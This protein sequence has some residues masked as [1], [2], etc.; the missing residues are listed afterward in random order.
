MNLEH[1]LMGHHQGTHRQIFRLLRQERVTVNDA[2]VVAGHQP[3]ETT[4]R[5][6]VDGVE[7]TGRQPQYL[8]FNRPLGFQDDLTPTT[9]RS[10]GSLLNDFDQQ[11]QLA[12][13]V[14]LP[15]EATG[16]VLV[17]DDAHF[18]TDLDQIGWASQLTAHFTGPVVPDLTAVKAATTWENLTLKRDTVQQTA[19]LVG[20]LHDVAAGVAAITPLPGLVGPVIR[21]QLGPLKLP[22]DLATG[23]Y[24]GLFP[25]EIDA[26]VAPLDPPRSVSR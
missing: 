9:A 8:M 17:S 3:L 7:V 21:T 26:L 1:Y 6:C 19:T 4:D 16:I 5:V 14:D 15:K 23:T 11:W 2:V 20:T 10:L 13:Q 22:N 24:R 25:E 12:A 18:L